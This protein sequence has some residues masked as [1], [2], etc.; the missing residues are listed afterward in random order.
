[1]GFAPPAANLRIITGLG[2]LGS[3]ESVE[4][5]RLEVWG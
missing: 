3:D 1:M 5:V 2:Q 4:K